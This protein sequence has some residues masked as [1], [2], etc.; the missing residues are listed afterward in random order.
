MYT[1]LYVYPI[2]MV[3]SNGYSLRASMKSTPR[4]LCRLKFT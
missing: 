1:H 4:Q 2:R 3:L